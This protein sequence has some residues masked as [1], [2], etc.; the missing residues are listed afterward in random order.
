MYVFV[1]CN[2]LLKVQTTCF[3]SICAYMTDH[4]FSSIV[5]IVH[6]FSSPVKVLPFVGSDCQDLC[7]GRGVAAFPH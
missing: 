3:Y 1:C 6:L 5:Q 7:V 2:P 4:M